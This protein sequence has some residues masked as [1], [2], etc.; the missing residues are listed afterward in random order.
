MGTYS[1]LAS[2]PDTQT[3]FPP[4]PSVFPIDSVNL[5]DWSSDEDIAYMPILGE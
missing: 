5:C 4:Q 3:V 1:V 2:S